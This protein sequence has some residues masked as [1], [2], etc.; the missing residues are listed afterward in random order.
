MTKLILAC[1][2]LFFH[3]VCEGQSAKSVDPAGLDSA[4][5]QN[6]QAFAAARKS[7]NPDSLFSSLGSMFTTYLE[8]GDYAKSFDYAEQLYNIAISS[9]EPDRI[10]ISLISLGTLY[11]AIED[12]PRALSYYRR[13]LAIGEKNKDRISAN[14]ELYIAEVY[15]KTAQFDSAWYYYN[16]YKRLHEADS[17][18]YRVSTGEC[19]FMQGKFLQALENF[20][21]VT[22]DPER[23]N[24]P[25]SLL[26]LARVYAVLNSPKTALK[27]GREGLQRALEIGAGQYIR[28]GYKIISDGYDQLGHTDSSNY[29]F[30]K[31]AVARDIVLNAQT[32][33]RMAALTYEQE[34][35]RMNQENEI[36]EIN[37]QR[38]VL[39]KNGLLAGFALLLL[40]AFILSRYLIVKRRAEIRQ[41]QI[42]ESE[43][44]IQKLEAEKSNAELQQQKTELEIK[45]LRAQ[46]NPHFIFNCLNSINRFI[47]GNE[48]AKAAD[49]LTKFARLIRIVLEKSG[50][51]LITLEEELQA[52]TLY[53]DLEALRFEK[54]FQYEIQSDG[55]DKEEL[56]VPSLLIQP[57]VENAIWH[58]FQPGQTK[59]GHIQIQLHLNND[60][61]HCVIQDN[62]IGISRSQS[63]NPGHHVQ[64]KSFGIAF[65]KERLRLLGQIES[66][67]AVEIQDRKDEHGQITGTVVQLVIP[68]AY[69]D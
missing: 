34:I 36:R 60:R 44:K 13:A 66:E 45:A 4:I 2:F 68:I 16:R 1:I 25:R 49:Y 41:R 43:L 10:S 38:Q 26:G 20:E 21:S 31:Y 40:I 11:S 58:G 17:V 46:M 14:L 53:M 29:Y 52:L 48:A 9:D 30:R 63:M 27:Y 64:G 32:R 50:V 42:V 51:S 57:F 67:P 6:N 37:L 59:R 33:G 28:D 18:L 62:G 15:A 69:A 7:G 19:F 5:G 65:T 35:S 23:Q 61:L 24:D 3:F 39:I 22:R 8:Y 54:P 12:Y 47:I 55:I 56:L